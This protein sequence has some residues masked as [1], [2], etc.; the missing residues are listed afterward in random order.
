MTSVQER[1]GRLAGVKGI[2]WV[3]A[4]VVLLVCVAAAMIGTS[5]TAREYTSTCQL[6]VSPAASGTPGESYQ[7][8]LMAQDRVTS[9]KDLAVSDRVTQKTVSAL[10]LSMSPDELKSR[11][12]VETTPQSVVMAVAVT[13][14]SAT[15]AQRLATG[16]CRQVLDAARWGDS[17]DDRGGPIVALREIQSPALPSGPSAPNP[18]RNLA[19]GLLAGVLLAAG[20]VVGW[21]RW[22]NGA[23]RVSTDGHPGPGEPE[24]GGSARRHEAS[25]DP[26]PKQAVVDGPSDP[27]VGTG[28]TAG[29]VASDGPEPAETA[30]V[31][32]HGPGL[33]GV[34]DTADNNAWQARTW[35][36]NRR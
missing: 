31:G 28:E 3:V 33:D 23:E 24:T 11:I 6:F 22:R 8:A 15:E 10:N 7:G 32:A 14:D 36:Q 25:T 18:S 20:V 34:R 12:S 4:I 26:I 30:Q 35:R 21:G 27:A 5:M 2:R 17:P 9:Y 16:V 29:D 13:G 1:L 19:I